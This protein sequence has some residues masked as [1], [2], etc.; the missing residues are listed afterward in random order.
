MHE[1]TSACLCFL[2][3]LLRLFRLDRRQDDI[4]QHGEVLHHV[5][6]LED[7]AHFV[8]TELC[9]LLVAELCGLPAVEDDLTRSHSVHTGHTVEQ[10]GFAG[11]GRS[12]DGDHLALTD[13][14]VNVLEH[15]VLALVHDVGLAETL[16]L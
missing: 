8:E 9:K 3:A 10:S 2:S 5:H 13:R 14:Q 4:V 11:A 1:R 15:V 16:C 7:E 6:L 12:H